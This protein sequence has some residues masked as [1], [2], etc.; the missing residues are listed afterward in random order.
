MA[1]IRAKVSGE[2]IDGLSLRLPMGSWGEGGES[3][4]TS[5]LE[6]GGMEPGV[7]E[8]LANVPGTPSSTWWTGPPHEFSREI[9]QLKTVVSNMGFPGQDSARL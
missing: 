5:G 6:M 1:P 3:Q 7:G 8:S 9:A 2:P 4:C